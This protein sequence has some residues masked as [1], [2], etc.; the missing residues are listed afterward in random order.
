MKVLAAAMVQTGIA[1]NILD[2]EKIRADV[3]ETET[4]L[5]GYR[6]GVLEETRRQLEGQ[7]RAAAAAAVTEGEGEGAVTKK[8]KAAKRKQFKRKAQQKKKAA[9]MAEAAAA[10]ATTA[11]AGGGEVAEGQGEIGERAQLNEGHQEVEQEEDEE[12]ETNAD[13]QGV[14]ATVVSLAA[15]TV[16]EKKEEREGEEEEEE[17]EEEECS[18][19]LNAI[20][21]GDVDNPAGPPLIWVE[22]CT[23]KCIEATCPYCRAPLQE[24]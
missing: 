1:T 5:V 14:P 6:E 22:K 17:E 10:A 7:R 16:G 9:E 20:H 24:L 2:A 4:I 11:A 15:M 23:S 12:E 3:E 18:V 21:S 8:S 19:C 13:L